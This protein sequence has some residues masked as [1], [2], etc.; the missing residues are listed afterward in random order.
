MGEKYNR[1]TILRKSEAKRYKQSLYVCMCDCGTIR[2]VTKHSLTSGGSK[3]C[4]CIAREKLIERST[5]SISKRRKNL[6]GQRFGRLVALEFA[7]T[8]RKRSYWKCVCD[9]GNTVKVDAQFLLHGRTTSCGCVGSKNIEKCQAAQRAKEL[10]ENTNLSLLNNVPNKN[11]KSGRK[12][13]Y[14]NNKKQVFIAK[15][16]FQGTRYYLGSF[17]DYEKAVIAREEAEER[18]FNPILEKYERETI[19]N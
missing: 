4:G 14:F 6:T 10:V 3:S 16:T 5:G 1:W 19:V 2:E 12:G 15:I 13:V 9:C 11:N 8:A 7:G 17:K 18:L